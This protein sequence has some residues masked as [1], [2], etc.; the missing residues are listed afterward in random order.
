M[1]KSIYDDEYRSLI[2]RLRDHRKS[3]G[4]T[5]QALADALGKPQSYVAK[6]EGCKR[7]LDVIEFKHWCK[8]LRV[9]VVEILTS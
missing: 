6:V 4:M 2:K 7:R 3:V 9:D 1:A 8:A 5:Q